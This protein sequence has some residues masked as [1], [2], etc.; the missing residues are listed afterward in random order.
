MSNGKV[1]KAL[2]KHLNTWAVSNSI[3]V[4][5]EG[6]KMDNTLPTYI[7]VT[8]V[9]NSVFNPS[10]GHEHQRYSG[11][12]RILIR[13]QTLGKGMGAITALADSMVAHFKRGMRLVQDDIDVV[14]ESTP[15]ART[16]FPD[17]LYHILPVDVEYRADYIS[18][19]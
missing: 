12:L 18:N 3:P 11:T 16:A 9:P 7:S 8:L 17:G 15:S 1:R 6:V 10:M 4:A 19:N 13:S 14:I 5:W 2:E